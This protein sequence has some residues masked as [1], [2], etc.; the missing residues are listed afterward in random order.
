MVKAAKKN[1][2]ENVQAYKDAAKEIKKQTH[3]S[4]MEE[5]RK[6]VDDVLDGN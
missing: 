1:D 3:E 4:I 6:I 5:N 2:P